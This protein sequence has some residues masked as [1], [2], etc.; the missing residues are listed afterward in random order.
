M[1][2]ESDIYCIGG[3]SKKIKRYLDY[4]EDFYCDTDDGTLVTSTL[5]SCNTTHQSNE[6][7]DIFRIDPNNPNTHTLK[8]LE[9]NDIN[10]I[11]LLIKNIFGN[12]GVK[13]LNALLR[14]SKANF[15]CIYRPNM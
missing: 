8:K 6:L 12:N 4:S 15:V 13:D 2:L 14:L 3:F 9:I 5:L 1:G 10:P 11:K 7:A